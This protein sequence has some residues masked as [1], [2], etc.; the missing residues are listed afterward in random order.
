METNPNGNK[1]IAAILGLVVIVAAIGAAA[2]AFAPK[3][4]QTASTAATTSPAATPLSATTTPAGSSSSSASHT[5]KDG[6][7][8]ATGTY[9]SPGGTEHIDVTVTLKGDAVS[10]SSV[11]AGSQNP[12]GQEYEGQFISAYKSFVTGKDIDTI[13]LSKVSGSSLTSGG[14]NNALSQIKSQAKA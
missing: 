14:F 8:K 5:Y 10:D 12:T 2:F 6:T 4:N 1:R 7:Y 13:S 3:K 11:V 9:Q